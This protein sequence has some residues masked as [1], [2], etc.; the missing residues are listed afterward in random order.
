MALASID[1]AL[2][3]YNANIP[4]YLSQAA[5]QAC[6]EAVQYLLINRAQKQGDRGSEM[7]YESLA[8][9]KTAIETFL[10]AAA[11]RAFGRSRINVARFGRGSCI[12]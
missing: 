6:L 5:A 2:A 10:G 11:P 8:K 3:Q 9:E 7:N 1:D 12:Q 4:W